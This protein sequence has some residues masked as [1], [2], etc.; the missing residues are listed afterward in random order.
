MSRNARR[1]YVRAYRR[2]AE[3]DMMFLLLV[4]DARSLV[5]EVHEG[6][7]FRTGQAGSRVRRA[8]EARL[9]AIEALQAARA[10]YLSATRRD[11]RVLLYLPAS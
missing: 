5:P 6:M 2:W 11:R 8:Y 3:A 1:L 10:A 7:V 4:R 9:R